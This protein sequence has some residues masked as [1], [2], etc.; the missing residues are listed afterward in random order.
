MSMESF[1]FQKFIVHD[2]GFDETWSAWCLANICIADILFWQASHI[3]SP[4]WA[5][6][7]RREGE[8]IMV[9]AAILASNPPCLFGLLPRKN[10]KGGRV[11]TCVGCGSY[12]CLKPTSLLRLLARQPQKRRESENICWLWQ[13]CCPQP[14]HFLLFAA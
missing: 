1:L 10:K 12:T 5:K 2:I 11:K 14:H 6:K 3:E 4:T 9:A 7:T 13:L 8:N